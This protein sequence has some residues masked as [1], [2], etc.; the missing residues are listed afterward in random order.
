MDLLLLLWRVK[1][2]GKQR[3]LIVIGQC[4]CS[5]WIYVCIFTFFIYI[6]S[7]VWVCVLATINQCDSSYSVEATA[8]KIVTHPFLTYMWRNYT[9]THT[10]TNMFKLKLGARWHKRHTRIL[11]MRPNLQRRSAGSAHQWFPGRWS[12]V[13]RWTCRCTGA[14]RFFLGLQTCKH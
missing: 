13:S 6:F 8:F 7:W 5:S 4:L 14:G 3:R 1:E 9:N 2:T 10:H 11:M 12:R